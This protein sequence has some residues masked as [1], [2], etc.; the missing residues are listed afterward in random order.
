MSDTTA[1]SS[2]SERGWQSRLL[3]VAFSL[4]VIIGATF[5]LSGFLKTVN[6]DEFVEALETYG[7][8]SPRLIEAAALIAPY[9]EIGMGLMLAF[10]LK[11]SALSWL[12]A[13]LLTI[14]SA[15]GALASLRGNVVDCGCFPIAGRDEVMGAGFF[16]RNGVLI[17]SCLWVGFWF[18][19]KGG[20]YRSLRLSDAKEFI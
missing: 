15:V 13:A 7:F 19:Q 4:R 1:R 9:A 5:S 14:L 8:L 18:R 16:I 17:I 12:L 2:C 3:K 20:Q 10:G 6:H 11:T